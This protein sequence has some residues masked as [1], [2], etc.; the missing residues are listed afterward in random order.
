MD[1]ELD[2]GAWVGGEQRVREATLPAVSPS[3]LGSWVPGLPVSSE[4]RLKVPTTPKAS[5]S[6]TAGR[7]SVQFLGFSGAALP[8]QQERREEPPGPS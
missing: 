7:Q 2:L 4:A 5:L 8:G 1:P 6:G 3:L